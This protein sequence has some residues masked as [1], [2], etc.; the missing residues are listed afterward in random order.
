MGFPN[1]RTERYSLLLPSVIST[2]MEIWK[3]WQAPGIKTY[4]YG[5]CRGEV[6][7]ELITRNTLN[8]EKVHHFLSIDHITGK[9]ELR[10]WLQ[11][12]QAVWSD[13]GSTT[14]GTM[15]SGIRPQCCYQK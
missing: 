14:S 10:S 11:I 8:P 13:P 4:I 5:K 2:V 6:H 15:S 9:M 1:T 3:S 12:S 7:I